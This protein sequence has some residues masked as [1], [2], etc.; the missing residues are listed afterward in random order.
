MDKLTQPV[1]VKFAPEDVAVLKS[2][3]DSRGMEASEY[4]RHL[5]LQDKEALRKQWQ[6]LNLIFGQTEPVRQGYRSALGTTGV[7]VA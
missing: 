2:L 6:T 1:S 3:A 7:D 5:V 4:I